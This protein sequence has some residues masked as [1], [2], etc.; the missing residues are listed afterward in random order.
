VGKRVKVEFEGQ[1]VDADEVEFKTDKEEWNSYTSEDGATI[2]LK[3]VVST[4]YKLLDRAKEDGSPVYL[5]TGT[6]LITA[7]H[8]VG[9]EV[10]RV[11]E[12]EAETSEY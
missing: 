10:D 1:Q 5:V 9:P 4:I 11:P 6:V 3:H 7:T 8:P 12:S 2:K